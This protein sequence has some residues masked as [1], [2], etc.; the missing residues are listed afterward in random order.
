MNNAQIAHRLSEFNLFAELELELVQIEQLAQQT[1]FL[2]MPRGAILFNQCNSMHGF[3]I[4]LKGLVKLGVSS[5]QGDEKVIGLIQPQQSFGEDALFLEGTFPTFACA[6]VDSQALFIPKNAIFDMLDNNVNVVRGMLALLSARNC[7]LIY[8]IK[9]ISLQNSTQRL[10]GYLLQISMESPHLTCVSLP[11][12][13]LTIASML[14]I[15]PETF[16]RVLLR[17]SNAGLIEVNGKEV[18]LNNVTELRNFS[19][20]YSVMTC[21]S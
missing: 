5:V 9:S 19:E 1:I 18:L 15:S 11:A 3:Y 2:E 20:V 13:R 7:Q 4:L 6:M 14:N 8:D 12:N 16:S 21:L 17:L 10:I